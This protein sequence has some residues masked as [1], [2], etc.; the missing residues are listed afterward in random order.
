MYRATRKTS[1]SSM[2]CY[3]RERTLRLDKTALGIYPIRLF[4]DSRHQRC[5]RPSNVS[6]GR[7]HIGPACRLNF[8][9]TFDCRNDLRT[10]AASTDRQATCKVGIELG[11]SFAS[12]SG[13]KGECERYESGCVCAIKTNGTESCRCFNRRHPHLVCVCDSVLENCGASSVRDCG[14]LIY[15]CGNSITKKC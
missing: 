7:L 14:A 15:A 5:L 8:I 11:L 6:A 4:R 1:V 10:W 13:C 3:A 9:G 2:I 12:S